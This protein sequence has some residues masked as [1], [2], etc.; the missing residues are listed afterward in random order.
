M[1]RFWPKIATG[2]FGLLAFS[3][4]QAG[5]KVTVLSPHWEGP[6]REFEAAFSRTYEKSTGRKVAVEWLD[7]GASSNI[8][9]YVRSEFKSRPQGIGIDLV[10]GGGSI[11]YSTLAAEDLLAP[12]GLTG[13]DFA[14]IPP[15]LAGNP[16]YDAQGLWFGAALGSFG[17]LCNERVLERMNLPR[18]LS[19]ADLAAPA[20]FSW[21]ALADPRD[22]G[23]A[24][25]MLELMFQ[26]Y[27]WE[28]GLDVVTRIGAN[29]RT[30]PRAA[31]QI[32]MLVATGEV[33]CGPCI[34]FYAWAKMAEVGPG[35]LE[36][37]LPTA[38]TVVTTD[39]IAMLKGAPDP[40]LARAFI[41][42]VLSPAGQRLWML[43]AGAEGGPRR[44]TLG[45][46]SVRPEL[47]DEL[48]GRMVMTYN[49]FRQAPGLNFNS[50][51]AEERWQTLNDLFGALIVDPHP[52][53][54]RAWESVKDREAQS[55]AW[56]RLAAPPEDEAAFRKRTE[57][58]KDPEKRGRTIA[59]WVGFGRAKYQS[60][61][62]MAGK[63]P[64]EWQ[65]GL[66][67]VVRGLIPAFMLGLVVIIPARR[68]WARW[69]TWRSRR[70][71]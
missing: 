39:P 63:E 31:S 16:L 65:A 1:M 12:A 49:P 19:W 69:R 27:G 53:L 8:M 64:G 7:V 71:R 35:R 44:Y 43:P 20:F 68:L 66:Y 17:I 51:L 67:R 33:A 62:R 55:P 54:V 46:L 22:S 15:E 21:V 11:Y 38:E 3:P 48:A 32:P 23:T 58:W 34:D 30:I 14:G 42:F 6:K 24:H 61:L 59:E 13:E 57:E 50:G 10:W 40:D 18:P 28:K 37:I 25:M 29:A 9:A 60:V 26:S 47:Y 70:E 41:R 4:V 36:F 2:L 5:P 52:L 45:R 56:K